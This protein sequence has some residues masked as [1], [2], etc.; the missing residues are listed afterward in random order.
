VQAR[1]TC[2]FLFGKQRRLCGKN[3]R[4]FPTASQ[5]D[6]PFLQYLSGATTAGQFILESD[7]VSMGG[8]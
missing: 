4:P 7:L 2:T 8:E 6:Q 3:E 5:P 1:R